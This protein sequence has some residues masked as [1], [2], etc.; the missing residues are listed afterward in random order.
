MYRYPERTGPFFFKCDQNN[1]GRCERT[2]ATE[3]TV[4]EEARARMTRE[5]WRVFGSRGSYVHCCRRCTVPR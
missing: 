2:I 3:T 1:S 5:N 4:F